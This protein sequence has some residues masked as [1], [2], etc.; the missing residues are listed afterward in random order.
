MQ[1]KLL[2]PKFKFS[3]ILVIAGHLVSDGRGR[4]TAA[5]WAW[6]TYATVGSGRGWLGVVVARQ[7]DLSGRLGARATGGILVFD[8]V[9]KAV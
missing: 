6:S 7:A 2:F 4:L 1:L 9:L 5:G 3:C 8:N